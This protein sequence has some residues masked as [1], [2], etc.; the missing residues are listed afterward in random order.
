MTGSQGKYLCQVNFVLAEKFLTRKSAYMET[1]ADPV[2]DLE[3]HR[4]IE[5]EEGPQAERLALHL[6]ERFS[7]P[8]PLITR[9]TDFGCS[10]GVYVRELAHVGFQAIGIEY[11]E[12]A[13]KHAV[14]PFVE[15]GDITES[16]DGIGIC[17]LGLCIEVAEHIPE[18]RS[19]DLIRFL[20]RHTKR[21][22]V[23]SAAIPGQGGVGHVNCQT[24][25]YWISKFEKRGWIVD[26]VET[27]K[28]IS[29]MKNGYHMGWMIQNAMV[30]RPI[31][32]S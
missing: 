21:W 27:D 28:M 31:R 3:Y 11:S 13:V 8:D 26:H 22:L 18:D 7:D 2:Y 17:E 4:K 23:F 25:T 16:Y 14:C 10:T 9:V 30:L 32:R 5:A 19:D 24:K 6:K 29:Y 1:N 15:W 20:I 12:D